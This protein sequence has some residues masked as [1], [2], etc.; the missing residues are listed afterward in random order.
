MQN[1]CRDF[2]DNKCVF[3]NVQINKK[4]PFRLTTPGATANLIPEQ[5]F[6]ILEVFNFVD[7]LFISYGHPFEAMIFQKRA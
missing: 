2:A 4:H 3:V 7:F 6:K 1:A 5:D